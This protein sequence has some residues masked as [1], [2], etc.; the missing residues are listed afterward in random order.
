MAISNLSPEYPTPEPDHSF[1]L[2]WGYNILIILTFVEGI[3]GTISNGPSLSYFLN[4]DRETL[5]SQLMILLNSTDL[6]VYISAVLFW[7]VSVS[8]MML[9]HGSA[10]KTQMVINFLFNWF[11]LLV[12]AT[13]FATCLLSVTRTI[14]MVY[15]FNEI[16]KKMYCFYHCFLLD[17]FAFNQ[18]LT[19]VFQYDS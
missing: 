10:E 1:G 14:C 17:P 9:P 13:A 3:G 2:I 11:N 7:G 18:C 6:L 15:S 19:A 12:A 8:M 16:K 4:K 5:A